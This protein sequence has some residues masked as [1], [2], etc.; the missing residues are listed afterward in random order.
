MNFYLIIW[1]I[2]SKRAYVRPFWIRLDTKFKLIISYISDPVQ[3]PI[4]FVLKGEL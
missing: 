1:H 4:M 3:D 2:R